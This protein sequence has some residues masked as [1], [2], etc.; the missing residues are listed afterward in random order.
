MTSNNGATVPCLRVRCGT[1]L[2]LLKDKE[3]V[4]ENCNF[5]SIMGKEPPYE[6]DS[7]QIYSSPS[8]SEIVYISFSPIDNWD[9]ERIREHAPKKAERIQRFIQDPENP[10]PKDRNHLHNGY[11]V[12]TPEQ[13]N[14]MKSELKILKYFKDSD[15]GRFDKRFYL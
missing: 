1:P 7:V 2:A 11:M 15:F 10:W 9:I 12:K 3:V 5:I 14:L 13:I 8:S 6:R 4:C